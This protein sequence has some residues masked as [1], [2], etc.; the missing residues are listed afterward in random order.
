MEADG[1]RYYLSGCLRIYFLQ[2][3]FNLADPAIE[4]ALHDSVAMRSF[5]AIDLGVEAAPNET[6]VCKFR[7]LLERDKLG[8]HLLKAVNQ[9][10]RESGI[11]VSNDTLVNATIINAPSS[12]NKEG[13]RDPQ[14]HQTAKGQQ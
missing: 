11:T 12:K 3:R 10:L 4:E 13:K 8:E 14:M 9:Y 6:T 5:V 1:R 2:L 7:H